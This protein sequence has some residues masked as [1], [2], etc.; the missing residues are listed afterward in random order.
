[1]KLQVSK[2]HLVKGLQTVCPLIPSRATLP[3]LSHV[4]LEAQKDTLVLAGT[5]LEIGITTTIPA[6]VQEEGAAAIPAKRLNDLIKELPNTTLNLTTRKNYQLTVECEKGVFKISGLPKEE[7]P[8][9]PHNLEHDGVVIDQ[10]LFQAMLDLTSFSVSKDETR[11]ALTGILFCLQKGLVRLVATDGRRL[12]FVEKEAM[13]SPQKDASIIIP[14]KAI[15][16][17]R[18]LLGQ[19][20]TLKIT[21][22]ENQISFDLGGT[23]LVS[24]LIDGKFPNYEQVIP[25]E[26]PQKLKISRETFLLATK[27]VHLWTT[28]ESPSIRL[29]VQPNQLILSKQ[30]P[31]LG[32]ARE[33]I[34]AHYS[35]PEFSIGFNPNYLI[36]VLKALPDGDVELEL[37]GPD[38]PGVIRTRDNYIYIVLPMQ[39]TS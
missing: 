32:E 21:I 17:L 9:L 16:E 25:P 5:D 13:S 6:H 20:P 19:A 29:D 28:Q 33:E 35:G 3:I 10:S 30:T 18:R 31:D 34:E 24:H 4:L 15:E 14:F 26:S 1:M 8:R 23:Q 2:E 22:K 7:F 36:D 27:R 37:P 39:L 38:R 11:Y 12:A